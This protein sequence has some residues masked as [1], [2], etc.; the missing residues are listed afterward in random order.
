MFNV[1]IALVY[2][3]II[4]YCYISKEY[5][6]EDLPNNHLHMLERLYI[7]K[8]LARFEADNPC[9]HNPPFNSIILNIKVSNRIVDPKTVITSLP[10]IQ[11]SKS[12]EWFDHCSKP[13][14]RQLRSPQ[15]FVVPRAR[16]GRSWVASNKR[17]HTA[18]WFYESCR[19]FLAVHAN[20]FWSNGRACEHQPDT[21]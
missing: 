11:C 10:C 2:A 8:S 15:L 18:S 13:V 14:H 6:P 16:F 5:R 4:N 19:P 9:L 20:L 17:C 21:P 3:D 7:T 12:I 1:H